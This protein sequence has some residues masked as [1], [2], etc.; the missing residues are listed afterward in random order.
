MHDGVDLP[1][2]DD[3][4]DERVTDV[5]AH[6]LGAAHPAQQV[7]ARRDRVDRDDVIDQR[8]LRQPGGQIPAEKPARTGDQDNLR[9]MNGVR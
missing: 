5:G 8:V 9:V 2:A 4:G 3:L 7:L 6:E 1:V